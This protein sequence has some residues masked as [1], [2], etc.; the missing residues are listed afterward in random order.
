MFTLCISSPLLISAWRAS[1]AGDGVDGGEPQQ[2]VH[3][4]VVGPAPHWRAERHHSGVQ[5]WKTQLADAV[6]W[7]R[8]AVNLCLT[9][10]LVSVRSGAWPTKPATT[11]ISQ[12][13]QPSVQSWSAGCSRGCS[14]VWRSRPAPAPEWGSRA[15][16]RSSFWVLAH[17]LGVKWNDLIMSG[18]VAVVGSLL[19]IAAE[20]MIYQLAEMKI[21]LYNVGVRQGINSLSLSA[22]SGNTVPRTVSRVNN[23]LQ[24][25]ASWR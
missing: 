8:A 22:V 12:W 25:V 11:S 7:C 23:P 20:K 10:C 2:H 1:P 13:T 4:R 24:Y 18:L 17:T 21:A 5:G 9:L 14:T 16:P 15:K 19:Q 6:L 3:Q